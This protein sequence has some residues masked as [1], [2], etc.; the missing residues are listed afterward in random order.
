MGVG[1]WKFKFRD[2]EVVRLR[3]GQP[4]IALARRAPRSWPTERGI[5][6]WQLSLTHTETTA[7]AVAVALG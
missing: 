6:A 4:R 7:M 2:V 5:T 3:S 1:L